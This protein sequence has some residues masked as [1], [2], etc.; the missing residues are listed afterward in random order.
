MILLLIL[1]CFTKNPST[2]PQVN[3][4]VEIVH[5]EVEIVYVE[6]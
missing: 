3:A 2:T 4:Q 1:A 6:Q 5:S